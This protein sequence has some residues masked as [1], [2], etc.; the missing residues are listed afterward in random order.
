MYIFCAPLQDL[1]SDMLVSHN[2]GA[3]AWAAG[4]LPRQLPQVHVEDCFVSEAAQRLSPRRAWTPAPGAA[5]YIRP[6]RAVIRHRA[7]AADHVRE[8]GY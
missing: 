3:I 4:N 7:V 2:W 8:P 1:A 6:V 5:A